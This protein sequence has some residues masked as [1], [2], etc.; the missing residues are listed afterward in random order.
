VKKGYVEKRGESTSMDG[1]G[2]DGMGWDAAMVIKS[3][4]RMKIADLFYDLFL[5]GVSRRDDLIM[6]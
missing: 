2:W 6:K 1:M 5:L 3:R 4:K